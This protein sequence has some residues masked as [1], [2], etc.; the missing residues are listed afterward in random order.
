M[1]IYERS[2]IHKAVVITNV[3][4]SKQGIIT[5]KCP[6]ISDELIEIIYTS[7]Y[8]TQNGGGIMALPEPGSQVLVFYERESKET[9]YLSTIVSPPDNT[10]KGGLSDYQVIKDKYLYSPEA[11]TRPK[12]VDYTN[13]FGAGLEIS[14]VFQPEFISSKVELKSEVG[15]KVILSDS[16]RSDAVIIRNEHGDGITVTSDPSDIHGERAIEIKSKGMQRYI[17]FQSDMTLLV[18]DGRDINIENYSTGA[19]SN[20]NT[21][22]KFGN[23]NL[24]SWNADVNI[25][26]KAD[27]GRIF[28]ITPNARIQIEADGS[29]SIES[30]KDIQLKSS[31]DLD[32]KADNAIRISGRTLDIKTDSDVRIDAGGSCGIKAASNNSLD[33]SQLHLNSGISQPAQETQIKDPEKTDYND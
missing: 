25:I 31:G 27:D 24:K 28:L 26:S 13:S 21:A 22:G 32:I 29:I 33:G 7:P 17:V 6:D 11:N 10:Q 16:P 15:K 9:Y 20:F 4:P 14:R 19:F 23:I 1:T 3:D 12:K 8:Y 5:V 18:V 2:R 30:N